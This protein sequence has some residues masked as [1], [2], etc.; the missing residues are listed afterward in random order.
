MRDTI[1][2]IP[3]TDVFGP[4]EGCPICRLRNMLENR[5]I[6]YIMGAAMMEP[7][8]RMETNK[9]GFCRDHFAR[10]AAQK[11]RLSLALMLETHLDELMKRHV[12]SQRKKGEPA[13]SDTCFVCREIDGAL[14]KLAGTAIKLYLTDFSF[15]TLFHEQE[16]ICMKHYDLLCSLAP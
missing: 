4:K 7:D 13:P 6:E 2:T 9:Y 8:I 5:C 14:R 3:L 16:F 1:Y 12:P 10:M 11:N 15:R